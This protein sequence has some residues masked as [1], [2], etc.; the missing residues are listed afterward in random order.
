MLSVL[1]ATRTFY[2]AYEE[3]RITLQSVLAKAGG[4]EDKVALL[5]GLLAI[6]LPYKS[7]YEIMVNEEAHFKARGKDNARRAR[8]QATRRERSGFTPED[9]FNP[10]DWLPRGDEAPLAVQALDLALPEADDDPYHGLTKE[11]WEDYLA[12]KAAGKI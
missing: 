5:E 6:Q 10:G 7:A 1:S 4:P 3:L 8:Y 2:K 9:Q 12:A 11:Q